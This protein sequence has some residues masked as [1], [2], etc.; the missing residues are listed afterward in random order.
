MHGRESTRSQEFAG[1]YKR[2][3]AATF[4]GNM[5]ERS[6]TG[7]KAE[8]H[9][10][11]QKAEGRSV[12]WQDDGEIIYGRE[13]SCREVVTILG[14]IVDLGVLHRRQPRV[15]DTNN[16]EEGR[17]PEGINLRWH[18]KESHI[19]F[20]HSRYSGT[21]GIPPRNMT[22]VARLGRP[23]VRSQVRMFSETNSPGVT[24][25]CIPTVDEPLEAGIIDA[26]RIRYPDII[27]RQ[28]K[29]WDEGSGYIPQS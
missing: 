3:K 27:G 18:L 24:A 17:R 5:M 26:D 19:G 7:V 29:G 2:R 25:R 13:S 6:C 11:L 1:V 4:G 22:R 20:L 12:R 28:H 9:R 14:S 15:R 16:A 21:R 23:G 10:S 8:D